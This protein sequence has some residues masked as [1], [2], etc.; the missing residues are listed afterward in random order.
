MRNRILPLLLIVLGAT[1]ILVA[2]VFLLG[3]DSQPTLL[4]GFVG[5]VLMLFGW[6][7]CCD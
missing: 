5:G 6:R 7:A 1:A 4:F 2:V 3:L